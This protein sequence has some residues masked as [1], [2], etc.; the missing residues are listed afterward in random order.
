MK[1]FTSGAKPSVVGLRDP[2]PPKILETRTISV[3]R[4]SESVNLAI[5]SHC[6]ALGGP[7]LYP[8][9][10]TNGSHC[11]AELPKCVAHQLTP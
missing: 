10:L 8:K 9:V 6:S 5:W 3:C 2:H 1:V 7:L 11:Q 4:W